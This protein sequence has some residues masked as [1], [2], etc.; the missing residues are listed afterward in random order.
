MVARVDCDT[1]RRWL[2]D[3]DEL[4]LFDVREHGQY[5]EAH[6][7]FAVPLPFSRLELDVERLAPRRGVRIVLVDDDER[8]AARAAQRLSAIGYRDVRVL[9]GGVPGWA[10]RGHPVYA[11]VNVPSKA[12]GELIEHACATPSVTAEELARMLQRGDDVLVLDGR[13]F[14]EYQKMNIPGAICCPNGELAYRLHRLVKDESTPIVVNCAGRTRSI[15]GAQTLISLGVRNPVRALQ[16]GTQGWTL[17]GQSL[18]RGSRHRYPAEGIDDVPP[19]L[20]ESA[21]VFADRA[22][23]GSIDAET[24]AA[25]R[26]DPDRTTFM[27]DVRTPEE[28]AAGTLA[29]AVHAPGGQLV[30][31]TDQYVGV[32]NARLVL[33]DD[34]DVRARVTAGWLRK[35]GHQAWVLAGGIAAAAATLGLARG[36]DPESAQ[37]TAA[38][39]AGAIAE[40]EADALHAGL[41]DAA[42][43]AVDLRPSPAFRRAHVAGSVWSIR[44]RIAARLD[45]ESRPITLVADDPRIAALA[46]LELPAAQRARLRLLRGGFAAWQDA[47]LPVLSTPADPP[48][49]ECIDFLFFVHDR[50][51]GNLDA[52]RRYL[53]WETG[54]VE[55]MDD[56]ERG[57]FRLPH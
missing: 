47:G 13:P 30:Q 7:F 33:V 24:L 31:A 4:A 9:D 27:L 28:F 34:G 43:V 54:L 25:W 56:L 16:N 21:Q 22:G 53:A 50:H 38:A 17:A 55:Q 2:A 11:G 36:G 23:A 57:A 32:R 18:E 19:A 49:A 41:R 5:G 40:I 52:A 10:A 51:D 46:A 6:L 3:G 44:P 12:F 37:Q 42:I 20:R 45:G 1:L 14:A 26:S 29:G 35:L 8:V 48:D 15:I 39:S